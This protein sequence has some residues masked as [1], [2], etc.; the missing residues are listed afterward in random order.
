MSIRRMITLLAAIAIA[1]LAANALAETEVASPGPGLSEAAIAAGAWTRIESIPSGAT[2]LIKNKKHGV[3]P[4]KI[5]WPKGKPPTIVLKKSPN[6]KAV[7]VVKKKDRGKTLRIKLKGAVD[8]S[9][10]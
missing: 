4:K 8:T 10:F 1:S 5:A 9:P 2:I 3:T 6:Y 7:V